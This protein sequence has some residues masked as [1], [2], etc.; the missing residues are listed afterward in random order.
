MPGEQVGDGDGHV[1]TGEVERDRGSA[2]DAG[3]DVV[4]RVGEGG[5]VVVALAH[6]GDDVVGDPRGS[7]LAALGDPVGERER[8]GERVGRRRGHRVLFSPAILVH[9][10]EPMARSSTGG[11]G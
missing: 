6:V 5:D 11:S 9:G 4:D 10:R 2:V 8:P 7:V 3:V 1:V